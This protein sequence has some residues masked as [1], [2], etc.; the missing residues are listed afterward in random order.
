MKELHVYQPANCIQ[1]DSLAVNPTVRMLL[2]VL[3][4]LQHWLKAAPIVSRDTENGSTV[5]LLFRDCACTGEDLCQMFGS[6]L[7]DLSPRWKA[8]LYGTEP[9]S[10]ETVWY[11]FA[12]E[13]AQCWVR[14]ST[15]SGRQAETIQSLCLCLT[16]GSSHEAEAVQQLL[17]AMD[18]K[19]GLA[20]VEWKCGDSLGGESG[21]ELPEPGLYCYESIFECPEAEACLAALSLE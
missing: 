1:L 7:A 16:C 10:Q 19:R 15:L 8:D 2:T 5:C 9:C 21:R 3:Y 20:A 13:E 6:A 17:R 14:E 11:R 4:E 12:R 18:W